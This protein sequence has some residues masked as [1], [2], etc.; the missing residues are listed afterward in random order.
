MKARHILGISIVSQSRQD[1]LEQIKKGLSDN[2]SLPHFFHIVS[3][4]PENLVIAQENPEFKK[5]I[6]TAQIKL[7]DGVGVV[8]AGQVLGIEVG[9][10]VPGVSLMKNILEMVGK[11]RLRALLIGGRPNLALSLSKC[12]QKKYPESQFFSLEGFHDIKNPLPG[13]EKA[14]FDIVTDRRPHFVIAAF[15]SPEQELWLYHNRERLKGIICMGVGGGFDF[16]SG[17]IKRAPMWM[18]R[19]GLEWFFRLVVQPW[20][21]RRQLRLIKFGWLLLKKRSSQITR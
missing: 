8:L 3:L 13:E 10:R 1:I 16:L 6:E 17:E 7:I 14:I 11:M 4:N 2:Q 15:G 18:Q 19:V 20:R 12:Y 9:E 21:W 5:V